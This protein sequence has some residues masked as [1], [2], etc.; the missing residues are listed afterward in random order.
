M[1]INSLLLLVV[2]LLGQPV[3]AGMYKWVDENGNIVYSQSM[4]PPGA[5][6]LEKPPLPKSRP[7]SSGTETMA[8]TGTQEAGNT[9]QA[10]T[11]AGTEKKSPLTPQQ[12][13]QYRE[14]C[15]QV[16]QNLDLLMQ[17]KRIY[18]TNDQGERHYLDDK[19]REERI[20]QANENIKRYC[21]DL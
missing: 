13:E 15:E 4:P 18:V 19:E 5:K 21:K 7:S 11:S 3:A 1:R 16:K 20:G 17:P 8:S 2:I 6:I 10:E 9:Q 14:Y 12:Q